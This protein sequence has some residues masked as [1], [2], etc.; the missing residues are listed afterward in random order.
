LE[1]DDGRRR[2]LDEFAYVWGD[3]V[4]I[5][6]L[7]EPHVKEVQGRYV[8]PRMI[9]KIC[10]WASEENVITADYILDGVGKQLQ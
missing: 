3:D 1:E 9:G 2:F 7:G 10:R 8:H 4:M 6:S 5:C